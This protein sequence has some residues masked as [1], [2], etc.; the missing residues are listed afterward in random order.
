MCFYFKQSSD[1]QTLKNRFKAQFSN[2]EN[3]SPRDIINAFQKP[4]TPIIKNTK[5]DEIE[6]YS[7]GLIPTWSKEENRLPNARIE[8]INTKPS[9]RNIINNRCIIPANG[10]YEWQWLDPKGK[11]KQKYLLT[12]NQNDIFGFAGLYS[13]WV[14]KNTGEIFKTFTILTMVANDLMSQIHNTKKRMPV[15]IKPEYEHKWLLDNQIELNNNLLQ[16]T[17]IE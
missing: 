9:F 15:I 11:N 6:L 7:W 2:Q 13:E 4:I 10:F 14:N 16:A 5:I 3:H 17:K 12:I 1:A 8:T